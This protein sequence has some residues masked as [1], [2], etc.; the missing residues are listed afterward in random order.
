MIETFSTHAYG[1]EVESW[2]MD[3]PAWPQGL[4][5]VYPNLG[6]WLNRDPIEEAGGINLYGFVE[7]DPINWIDPHGL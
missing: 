3:D 6:R 5:F 4:T 7:N 1:G 2:V